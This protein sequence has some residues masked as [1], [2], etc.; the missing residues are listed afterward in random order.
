VRIW[1]AATSTGQEAYTL[2]MLVHEWTNSLRELSQASC[3]VLATDLCPNALQTA[4]SGVYKD[5]ELKNGISQARQLRYFEPIH[6]GW[7]VRTF[8][9]PSIEF[10]RFNLIDP[11]FSLG[12]FELICC[13]NVLIYFD[14]PTRKKIVKQMH[15]LLTEGGWLL[16]GSAENLYGISDCFASVTLGNALLY[17]AL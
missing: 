16:L 2:A 17:R 15:S 3:A 9:R 8:L 12:R 1:S 5:R 6:A 14:E 7:R 4:A 13:R 10:R 11:L